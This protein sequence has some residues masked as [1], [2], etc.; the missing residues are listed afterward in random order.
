MVFPVV[1]Y[2]CKSW[3]IKKV[4][5]KE[6]MLL[7]CGA[8]EDSWESLGLWGDQTSKRRSILNIHG[9]DWC[10]G[11]SSRILA[12]WGK[13]L[14]P[15][16]RP[17][18][19]SLEL[20]FQMGIN[21]PFLLCLFL[22]FFSQLFLR[23]PQTTILPICISFSWGWPWSLTPVQCY[24]SPSIFLQALCLSDLIPWIHLSLPLYNHKGFDLGHTWM[25]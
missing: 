11:W 17:C 2:K 6:L 22:H 8:G 1:M 20:C 10:R 12:T 5:A 25:A 21:L 18:C 16:K 15:W 7:N 24:E 14:T 23:P 4:S 13:E 9:K 3:T 19:Y